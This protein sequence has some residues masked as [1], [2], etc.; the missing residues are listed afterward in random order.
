MDPQAVEARIKELMAGLFS[1]DSS[2][3]GPDSSI[4]TV[5]GWDSLQHV[6]L[7]M[8][9]EQ[10]FSVTFEVEDAAEMTTFTAVCEALLRYLNE[11]G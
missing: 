9:M 5:E 1:L 7:I 8:A 10:E 2:D 3:V 4:E 6:N 11:Q